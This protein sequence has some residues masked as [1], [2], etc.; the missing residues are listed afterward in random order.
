M[1]KMTIVFNKEANTVDIWFD[2]PKKEAKAEETGQEIIL[3]RDKQGNIIGIEKINFL[4]AEMQKKMP[5]KMPFEV[6]VQ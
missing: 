4:K 3:K 5:A 2:D 6:I 1:E